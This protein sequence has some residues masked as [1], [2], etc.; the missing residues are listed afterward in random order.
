MSLTLK[1]PV[2]SDGSSIPEKYARQGGNASPPLQWS[3]PPEGTQSYALAVEDPDAPGG[4]FHH[5]AI[6]DLPADRRELADAEAATTD[7][8]QAR[9]DFDE[10]GYGGPEP[11]AGHGPHRYRFRLLALDVPALEVPLGPAVT[12]VIKAAGP[13]VIEEAH[14]TGTFERQSKQI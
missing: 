8:P 9:N 3:A 10:L 4:T 13:H 2:F 6:Y 12:E 14:L 11:P 1:S 5:W 7:L